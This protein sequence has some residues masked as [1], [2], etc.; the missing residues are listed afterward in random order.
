MAQ[1]VHLYPLAK[2]SSVR[3]TYD[4]DH[5]EPVAQWIESKLVISPISLQALA[6]V[7]AADGEDIA[8]A[9]TMV[10]VTHEVVDASS[11]LQHVSATLFPPSKLLIGTLDLSDGVIGQTVHLYNRS[12]EDDMKKVLAFQ[13]VLDKGLVK[14]PL[15]AVQSKLLFKKS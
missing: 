5:F 8:Q 3:S 14:P 13:S 1:I 9:E 12:V 7:F 4:A 6:L 11:W 15:K 2:E 10:C